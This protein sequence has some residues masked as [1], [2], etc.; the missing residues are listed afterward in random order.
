[1][2]PIFRLLLS[3]DLRHER[4]TPKKRTLLA[5][6]TFWAGGLLTLHG[7]VLHGY[8]VGLAVGL[9]MVLVTLSFQTQ[10]NWF[11]GLRSGRG[12]EELLGSGISTAALCDGAACYATLFS[13]SLIM[14][15]WSLLLAGSWLFLGSLLPGLAWLPLT[16]ALLAL[17]GY[18]AQVMSS[19]IWFPLLLAWLPL[20]LLVSPVVS[21]WAVAIY[22]LM[23]ALLTRAYA[24]ASM[25]RSRSE[26]RRPPRL[27][28]LQNPVFLRCA[29]AWTPYHLCWW[30]AGVVAALLVIL[31]TRDRLEEIWL[32]LTTLWVLQVVRAAQL[33]FS[34]LVR[35]RQGRTLES[36]IGS[37]L[38]R[39]E[40]MNGW[41]LAGWV[42]L[43]VEAVPV[44]LTTLVFGLFKIEESPFLLT[45]R[46][47]FYPCAM[48][49]A[50]D[51]GASLLFCLGAA[52]LTLL[53]P[54]VG[55]HLGLWAGQPRPGRG[56]GST[57]VG[58]LFG[59]SLLLSLVWLGLQQSLESS[60]HDLRLSLLG[61]GLAAAY[62]SS[63]LV[64]WYCRHDARSWLVDPF[65]SSTGSC[66]PGWWVIVPGS[67][68]GFCFEVPRDLAEAAFSLL[69]PWLILGLSR[70]LLEQLW[71]G[72][73]RFL[74]AATVGS[75]TGALVSYLTAGHLQGLFPGA[76]V[77]LL[78]AG[79]SWLSLRLS[80][81]TGER[82][83]TPGG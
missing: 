55:A 61:S 65:Q 51:V 82:F 70:P 29:R 1:M 81:E 62:A 34:Q 7:G 75:A 45:P 53:A 33:T 22:F 32:A 49:V 41:L 26:S 30:N 57:L 72:G 15:A 4:L 18:A 17:A 44:A 28:P 64:L 38:E 2:N 47:F 11:R 24:L 71:V 10:L 74:S 23:V 13:L 27:L 39:S 78:C 56:Q 8:L 76:A 36:L 80:Q 77:G 14:P 73:N 66:F 67:Y 5:L 52:G 20:G 50:R 19:T 54:V 58:G 43:M 9:P 48:P 69:L 31:N 63:L 35:E 6:G 83:R 12:L 46:E 3:K 42:P 37:G 79:G 16:L 25:A 40:L 60:T 21:T 59:G 68:A